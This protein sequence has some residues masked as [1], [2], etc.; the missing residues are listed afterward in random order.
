V[1]NWPSLCKNQSKKKIESEDAPDKQHASAIASPEFTQVRELGQQNS[2]VS[3]AAVPAGQFV[4]ARDQPTPSV[5]AM[6]SKLG[7]IVK[8]RL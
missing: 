2:P 8:S 1:K 7:Q 5:A 3:H 4:D 6:I